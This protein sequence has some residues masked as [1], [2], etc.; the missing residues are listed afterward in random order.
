MAIRI[1]GRRVSFG[2]CLCF[3][4]PVTILRRILSRDALFLEI[5]KTS[6]N[7]VIGKMKPSAYY[8]PSLQVNYQSPLWA[9]QKNEE[10]WNLYGPVCGIW[11]GKA[12]DTRSDQAH[13]GGDVDLK[14]LTPLK[15]IYPKSTG[16]ILPSRS[17]NWTDLIIAREAFNFSG[18]WRGQEYLDSVRA[19]EKKLHEYSDMVGEIPGMTVGVKNLYNQGRQ[20]YY[21]AYRQWYANYVKSQEGNFSKT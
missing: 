20:N 6:G 9:N 7:G 10:P 12:C 3:L 21:T 19:W 2:L 18:R 13:P 1:L 11:Y 5:Q 17:S 14:R 4:F 16:R 15:P 8:P